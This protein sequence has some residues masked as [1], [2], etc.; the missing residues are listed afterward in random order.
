MNDSALPM[1]HGG[2]R[3]AGKPRAAARGDGQTVAR[4]GASSPAA[5]A[6]LDLRARLQ[7]ISRDPLVVLVAPVSAGSGGSHVARNLAVAT[8]FDGHE[9]A[10]LVDCD[11]RQPAQ[12]AALRVEAA[13]GGLADYLEDAR[14]PADALLCE[15]GFPRLRLL[16]AGVPRKAGAEPFPTTRMRELLGTLRDL[17]PDWHVVLDGPPVRN[18]PE[19][20]QLGELADAV[21]L[22]AGYGRDTPKAIARAA[23]AF[24]PARFAG[25]VFNEGV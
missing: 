5:D 4:F 25:V 19:A 12:Q 2:R 3:P 20:R 1:G 11:L 9:A 14:R 21:I 7:A 24:D 18:G 10:V 23:A 15:S 13:N 6:F 16:P 22:V 8:T 17:H